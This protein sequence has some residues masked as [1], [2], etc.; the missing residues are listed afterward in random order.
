MIAI[1]GF[2]LVALLLSRLEIQVSREPAGDYLPPVA[3]NPPSPEPQP[4]GS[5]S[6][7]P[8]PAP[9]AESPA[10]SPTVAPPAPANS[11]GGLRVSNKT[12]FPI[13][14]ALLYQTPATETAS[15]YEQPVHWDFAPEEGEAKGL[16][17]SLPSGNLRLR[18][19]DVLVG[20]AQD[21]SRR[22]WGPYIVGKTTVPAWSSEQQEWSL[23]FQP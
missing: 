16:I 3:D 2:S 19:G 6:A 18:A 17:V 8:L 13:R 12:A 1:L 10:A 21:G 23:V 9:V 20:F 22:Y 7:A 15:T 14:L 5:P 11:Q 4:S